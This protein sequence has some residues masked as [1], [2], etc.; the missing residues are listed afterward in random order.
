[1]RQDT[2]PM[3]MRT[4]V[5]C[6][7]LDGTLVNTTG[8][9]ERVCIEAFSEHDIRLSVEK[10]QEL[11][12]Q[13]L[14]TREWFEAMGVQDLEVRKSILHMRDTTMITLLEKEAEWIPGAPEMLENIRRRQEA[15]RVVTNS[16]QQFISAIRRRL[17]DLNKLVTEFIS[18]DLEGIEPKPHDS[19][20]RRAL[21]Q[22]P[23]CPP[24]EFLYVGDQLFDRIAATSAGALFCAFQQSH[25][26]AEAVDGAHFVIN[27][28][29]E[30]PA[31][32]LTYE[33]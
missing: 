25:T 18:A 11:S 24:E 33:A 2:A 1:M 28:L 29:S 19:G 17:P 15:V 5:L 10:F 16:Q 22:H 12:G 14:R 30:L 27:H 20:I 8:M 21:D 9:F 13:G 32:R 26:H 3:G 31:I 7:D 4:P 23:D 6:F